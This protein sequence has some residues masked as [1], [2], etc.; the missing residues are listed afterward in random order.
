MPEVLKPADLQRDIQDLLHETPP[1]EWVREMVAHYQ[2]TGAFRAEDLRRLLGDPL[3]GVE[4]GNHSSLASH[5]IDHSA[6]D[7]S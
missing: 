5:F 1:P 2:K 6:D 7:D 4:V 3:K